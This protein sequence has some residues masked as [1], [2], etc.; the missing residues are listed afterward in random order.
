[1]TIYKVQLPPVVLGSIVL[2][3]FRYCKLC[4]TGFDIF[5]KHEKGYHY[6]KGCA[7]D[8]EKYENQIQGQIF[9]KCSTWKENQ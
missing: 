9:Q 3:S 6:Q 1:M 2:R 8:N 5:R 7:V 4:N